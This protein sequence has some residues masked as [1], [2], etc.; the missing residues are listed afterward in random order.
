VSA[1][2]HA[3]ADA[4]GELARGLEAAGLE[5]DRRALRAVPGG[6]EWELAGG[7]LTLSFGLQPGEYAT[8]VLRELIEVADR[9]GHD[10]SDE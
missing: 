1:L 6:L 4:H 10:A 8:T 9:G 3:V 7:E 2:E 5:Q